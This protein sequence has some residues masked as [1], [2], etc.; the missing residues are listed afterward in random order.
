MPDATLIEV[1]N[2]FGYESP[3]AFARD[4]RQLSDGDKQQL[5][6]GIGSETLTY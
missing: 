4:W 5:K 6:A 2:Y 3:T 1:K